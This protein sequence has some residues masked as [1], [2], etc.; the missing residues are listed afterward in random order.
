[1][2]ETCWCGSPVERIGTEVNCTGSEFHDPLYKTP[3]ENPTYLYLSGPMSNYPDNNYPAFIE[4]A[5]ELRAAGFTVWNPAEIGDKGSQY[6]DLLRKDIAAVL[7]VQGVATLEGWW[8]STGARVEI[9]VAGVLE[10]PVRSV[11]E[12]IQRRNSLDAT[13]TTSE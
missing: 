8:A 4:A 1:M 11:D 5:A 13:A 9:H 6:S 12:W 10:L 7:E 3:P 2:I